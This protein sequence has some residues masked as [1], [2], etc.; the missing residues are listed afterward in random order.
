MMK[1]KDYWNANLDSD[2]LSR[3]EG[4]RHARPD[5]SI[6]FAQTPEFEWLRRRLGR[7]KG[8][9]LVDLGGGI[10][11]HALI[12]AESGARVIVID[13]AIR[14]LE[15]LRRHVARAGLAEH[16]SFVVGRGDELPILSGAADVVFTKSV[17]IHTDLARAAEETC[18]ILRAGGRGVFIEPRDLNPIIRLYRRLLAPT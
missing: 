13:L 10:G 11:R 15:L 6:V 7:V 4:R 14:R 5:E 17:L 1:R 8:R 9:T 2:N 16:V 18:R 3:R 12:W